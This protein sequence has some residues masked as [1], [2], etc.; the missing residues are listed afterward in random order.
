MR[1]LCLCFFIVLACGCARQKLVAPQAPTPDNPSTPSAGEVVTPQEL[2][3]VE[4]RIAS[5]T[6]SSSNATQN[7]ITGLGVQVTKVAEKVQGVGGDIAAVRGDVSAVKG[8]IQTEIAAVKGNVQADLALVRGDVK[9]AM[10]AVA[11]LQADIKAL[12]Q[13]QVGLENRIDQTTA[14]AGRDL[15]QTTQFSK[16]MQKVLE[17]SYEKR[18]E[19]LKDSNKWR[20][21]TTVALLA[22][23]LKLAIIFTELS[24]RRAEARYN[25]VVKQA[26]KKGD[27]V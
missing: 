18:T 21:W 16:E 1:G 26:F 25:E 3:A 10:T 11:E 20:Y 17:A 5:E 19:E 7:A 27:V 9:A 23:A 6:Q 14:T 8:D 12:A 4:A 24:R 22:F 2:K 15:N 13:G